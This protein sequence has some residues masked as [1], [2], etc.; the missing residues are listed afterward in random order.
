MRRDDPATKPHSGTCEDPID[1]IS[2]RYGMLTSVGTPRAPNMRY[3]Y[4]T[5]MA[6]I[7][8]NIELMAPAVVVSADRTLNFVR[9]TNRM[10]DF[11]LNC[12]VIK[13]LLQCIFRF[14]CICM[15]LEGDCGFKEFVPYASFT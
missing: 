15:K 2:V 3:L 6:N 5:R 13:P 1:A 10:I 9:G 8:V 11:K 4:G 7:E 14:E 12:I